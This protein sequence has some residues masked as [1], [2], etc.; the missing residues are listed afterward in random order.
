VLAHIG[1]SPPEGWHAPER[2]K[3]QADE[4]SEQWV[5]AYQRDAGITV[6]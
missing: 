1:V 5:A 6:A 3:R 4:L 2:L